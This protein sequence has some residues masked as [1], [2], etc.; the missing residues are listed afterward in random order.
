M[1]H[2]AKE[3]GYLSLVYTSRLNALNTHIVQP[4][5]FCIYY[6][7]NPWKIFQYAPVGEGEDASGGEARIS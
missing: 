3:A 6:F 2:I 5:I 4:P 1:Y 7:G